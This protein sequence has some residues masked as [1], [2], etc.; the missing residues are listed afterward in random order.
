MQ[1][2]HAAHCVSVP[3]AGCRGSTS[4]A[5]MKFGRGVATPNGACS[6]LDT[7]L[8]TRNALARGKG[9]MLPFDPCIRLQSNRMTVP[10]LPMGATMP[11]RS[12]E[13]TSELQSLMRISYAVF[14]LKKTTQKNHYNTN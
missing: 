13:H 12:E 3:L 8:Y 9:V 2:D 4:R 5:A 14:C 6:R 11:W 1:P 7:A 10:G